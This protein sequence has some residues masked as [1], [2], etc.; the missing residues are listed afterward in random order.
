MLY[1]H[2]CEYKT[3]VYDSCPHCGSTYFSTSS[4]GIEKVEEEFKKIFDV[5]Y[6]VLD[7]DRSKT[8][9]QIEKVLDD[10]NQNKAQILIG[11]QII[12]KG[13]DFKNVSFVGIIDVDFLIN[14][15]NFRSGE[16]TFSLITQTIG[17]YG[18]GDNCRKSKI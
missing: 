1:C 16:M 17:R 5:P 3:R 11:T 18:R 4:Y 6:L 10:F 12:S 9:Y 14:F 15:P 2:H 13:H 7:S 8:T